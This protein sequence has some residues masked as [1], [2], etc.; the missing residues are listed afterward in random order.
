MNQKLTVS[1]K[2][3]AHSLGADL[4]GVAQTASFMEAPK[5]HRRARRV[6]PVGKTAI[7]S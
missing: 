3:L 2:E 5:R 1:V 6:C 4:V 7:D